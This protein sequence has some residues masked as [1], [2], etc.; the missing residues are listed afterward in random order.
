[1][2][3][4][5]LADNKLTKAQQAAGQKKRRKL[6][7]EE[8]SPKSRHAEKSALPELKEVKRDPRAIL[9]GDAAFPLRYAF[10]AFCAL[11]SL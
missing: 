9:R 6:T 7:V 4:F 1:M 3:V 10:A 5:S 8:S 11:L 2:E